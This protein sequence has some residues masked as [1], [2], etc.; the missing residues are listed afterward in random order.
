MNTLKKDRKKVTNKMSDIKN[1]RT[2]MA[3]RKKQIMKRMI[4]KKKESD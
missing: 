3:L 4:L 1:P 2:L